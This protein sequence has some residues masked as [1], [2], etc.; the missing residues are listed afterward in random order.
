MRYFRLL[1]SI[2]PFFF[3]GK[4]FSQ[5]GK[6]T[7]SNMSGVARHG[8]PVIISRENLRSLMEVPD[9]R[10]PV[11]YINGNL[12]PSQTDDLG[13]DGTW[14]EIAFQVDMERNSTVQVKV[15]WQDPEDAPVHQAR[16]FAGLFKAGQGPEKPL[17]LKA[18]L[19][20]EDYGPGSLVNYLY[21]GPFWESES[22]AFRY[23]FDDRDFISV[24][25]KNQSGLWRDSSDFQPMQGRTIRIGGMEV[26]PQ[27]GGPGCGGNALQSDSGFSRLRRP[28]SAWFRLISSGP[29]RA[30]FDLVF[31]DVMLDGA[32]VQMKKRISIW[33]GKSWYRTEIQVSG[34]QGEKE[35]LAGLSLP[36]KELKPALFHFNKAVGG[37]YWHGAFPAAD[38]RSGQGILFSKSSSP[39]YFIG[40]AMPGYTDPAAWLKFRIRSGQR[41]EYLS[42][43]AWEKPN[44]RFGNA[45]NF[46]N[47]MQE[48]ADA[49]E[50]PLRIIK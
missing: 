35:M 45:L 34:F 47:M 14:D 50:F 42:F 4:L 11:L 3:S 24:L 33:A 30:M 28:G 38:S 15:K 19:R 31:E 7:I 1:L 6:F 44:E 20:P 22:I 48:E 40:K 32:P 46:R 36:I 23:L 16:V 17:L 8:E 26:L 13:Q 12:I 18:E 27:D 2:L 25:G 39:E 21:D 49:L 9:K 41:L 37:L 10:V 29:V 43:A 5:S